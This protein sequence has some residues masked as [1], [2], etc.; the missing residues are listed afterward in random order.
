MLW[1]LVSFAWILAHIGLG[2]VALSREWKLRLAEADL[3]AMEDPDTVSRWGVVSQLQS[4]TAMTGA[5]E[6]LGLSP[7]EIAALGGVK[8]H[9]TDYFSDFNCDLSSSCVSCEECPICLADFTEGETLRQ[10]PNC[11][12]SFHRSCIDLWLLQSPSCPLCKVEVPRRSS[13][14]TTWSV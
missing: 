14:L 3:R 9:E 1:Q 4:D 7:S 2:C 10:L 13:E 6:R 5:P 12:H 8:V 11:V